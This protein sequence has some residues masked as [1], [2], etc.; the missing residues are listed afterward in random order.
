MTQTW[1]SPVKVHA[2]FEKALEA[3]VAALQFENTSRSDLHKW[4]KDYAKVIFQGF[5][6]G[7]RETISFNS[8]VHQNWYC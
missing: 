5:D 1:P 7:E 3:F 2:S 6:P 4:Q 8:F